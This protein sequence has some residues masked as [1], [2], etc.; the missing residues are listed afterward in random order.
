MAQLAGFSK[1]DRWAD[2]G[3]APFTAASRA[4]VTVYRSERAALAP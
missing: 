2:W 3:R 4:H 1:E